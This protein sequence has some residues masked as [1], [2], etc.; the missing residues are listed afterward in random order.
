MNTGNTETPHY[1]VFVM[2]C[3]G[4]FKAF[5]HK[6]ARWQHCDSQFA[7]QHPVSCSTTHKEKQK[8]VHK[9][10]QSSTTNRRNIYRHVIGE[11]FVNYEGVLG[12]SLARPTSRCRR[13]ES[14]VSL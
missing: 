10:N 6:L 1:L 12:K 14:I 2:F 11:P 7:R 4:L 3:L 9:T 13:T 5:I 8:K